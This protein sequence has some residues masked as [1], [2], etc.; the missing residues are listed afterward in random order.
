[1]IPALN[2][3]HLVVNTPLAGDGTAGQQAVEDHVHTGNSFFWRDKSQELVTAFFFFF[4]HFRIPIFM[5]ELLTKQV[6]SRKVGNSI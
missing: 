4:F 1:M 5:L 6:F 3:T 2:R